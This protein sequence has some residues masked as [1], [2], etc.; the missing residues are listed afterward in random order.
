MTKI[1]DFPQLI[2]NSVL[3]FSYLTLRSIPSLFQTC[4]IISSQ[5]HNHAKHNSDNLGKTLFDSILDNDEK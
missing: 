4:L 2:K 5:V 1:C 3:Y